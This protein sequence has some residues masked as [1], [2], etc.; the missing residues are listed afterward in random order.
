MRRQGRGPR[1]LPTASIPTAS[2]SCSGTPLHER[3][4][5]PSRCSL[6]PDH[7]SL[8][9]SEVSQGR[10]KSLGVRAP[11][12]QR[13]PAPFSS[14]R[15]DARPATAMLSRLFVGSN[16]SAASHP[17]SSR[18]SRA[19]ALAAWCLPPMAARAICSRLRLQPS[20]VRGRSGYKDSAAIV[21]L[22]PPQGIDQ[23]TLVMALS[24]TSWPSTIRR[25][26]QSVSLTLSTRPD[27]SSPPSASRHVTVRSM[28]A[29]APSMR[30][31]R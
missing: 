1:A 3:T 16:S 10:S 11:R 4:P 25:H 21:T 19:T 13:L 27:I 15:A 9:P 31:S 8:D 23:L 28:S 22:R 24:G 5:R 29:N 12:R 18:A 20:S 30:P 26:C 17:S 14:P 6:S 2:L 7:G